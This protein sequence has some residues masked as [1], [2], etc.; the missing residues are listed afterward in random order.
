MTMSFYFLCLPLLIVTGLPRQTII[1][2][3][4]IKLESLVDDND[5]KLK[6]RTELWIKG[7]RCSTSLRNGAGPL[8][9]DLVRDLIMG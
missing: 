5:W 7:F 6:F 9:Y 8:P 3:Y 4:I 1:N 2:C